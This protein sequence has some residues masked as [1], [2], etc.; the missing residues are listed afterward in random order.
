M[1]RVSL[2]FVAV[3]AICLS[4]ADIQVTTLEPWGEI[5]RIAQGFVTPDVSALLGIRNAFL[6]TI[7]FAFCGISL[8][9]VGGFALS[10]FFSFA[11]VRLGCALVR[12]IHEI[13]WAFLL[14]PVVGLT[15]VCG[16][17]AI[18]IPYAG[19]FGKVYAEIRQES[20]QSSLRGLPL[21]AGRLSRFCYGVLPMIWYDVK[22]YTSYRMECAL[23]SSAVLGFI[24]LPTLGFHLETALREGHYSEAPAL[25]YAFYLLIASLRYWVRPRLVLAYVVAS[26]AFLSTEVHLSWANVTH[27]L[28]YEILPWPMRRE[29]FYEGTGEVHLALG[30]VLDWAV[31]LLS[32]E[33]LEGVWN[34]I[35]LTQIALVGTG[36]FA[37]VAYATVSRH[38][39]GRG[40]RALSGYGLI[41]L[42]T[43]PE[44]ILAY[45]LLQFCGPS[46][47]PA[48]AAIMLH[49]GAILGYLTGTSADGVQ[50]R[51]D[52][53]R[54]RRDRY[55]YEITPRVYGR[56]LAFLFYRWEIIMRESAILGILGIHTLGFFIDSAIS[57][58]HLDK[59]VFLIVTT[60]VLNMAIDM[61]S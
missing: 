15:P 59:A 30:D 9:V 61:A 3:A 20:D 48:I 6:N 7:T 47:L 50:L 38:F 19:V 43:T 28:T 37:L 32:N 26:F 44:Y 45:A 53:P 31:Q 22:A 5:G 13:F 4:L 1:L 42:R 10:L 8:G 12:S 40:V 24:G 36:I 16:I 35:V 25:L 41:V 56:F 57:D 33:V 46:M 60:A 29:G 52:A 39:A 17:L 23:R 27:F 34:T 58:D 21:D 51:P 55:F 18:G 14:L 11:P 49:N 2:S 54:S